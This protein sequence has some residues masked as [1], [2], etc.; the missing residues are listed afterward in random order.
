MQ[1]GKLAPNAVNKTLIRLAQILEVAVEYGHID[2]NPAKGKR[3][4]AKPTE[5]KRSWVEPEQLIALIDA[6][7]HYM[8][9]MI[10]TLAGAGLRIGEATALDWRDVKLSTGVLIVRESKTA[11]GGGGRSIYQSASRR[12]LRPGGR[13]A[14]GHAPRLRCSLAVSATVGTQGRRPATC[15]RDSL[16]L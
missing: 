11:A 1:E 12:S 13:E 14:Q 16:R 5:P 8:R 10:A 9:P 2:R 3:R 7:D 15:R 4:R 6:A